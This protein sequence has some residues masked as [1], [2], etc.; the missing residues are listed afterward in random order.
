M[1]DYWIKRT[2]EDEEKAQ[3]LAKSYSRRQIKG[4]KDA[5]NEIQKSIDALYA[6]IIS[7]P[8]GLEN[9]TRSQ[10]WQYKKYV[11]LRNQIAKEV[12][13]FRINQTSIADMCIEDVFE[14]TMK[15]KLDDL[16]ANYSSINKE[17][18]KQY[19]NTNWAGENYS[20]RIWQNTNNLANRLNKDI[21][22]M[23]CLGKNPEQVKAALMDDL[24]VSYRMADRLIRTEASHAYN[25]ASLASYK[26]ANVQEVEF[27]AESDCCD[28]CAEYAGKTFP[29]D[30]VPTLPI[31][32]NCRCCYAPVV[33]LEI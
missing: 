20:N 2:Q 28:Q 23:I 32:P 26:E 3:R 17:Q 18:M 21:A 29:V 9:I 31:H 8:Q 11:E 27:I 30:R 13:D 12:G 4:Y 33:E 5:Y 16:G 24:N 25:S 19:L 10:L 15:M 6:E 1:S 7:Q 22:D 14:R